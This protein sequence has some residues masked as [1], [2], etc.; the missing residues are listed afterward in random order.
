MVRKIVLS[1]AAVLSVVGMALA[2]NK[3][4]SGTVTDSHGAPVPGATVVVDG[5]TIGTSTD[6]EGKYTLDAPVDGVLSVSFIG[7][8][9]Q[10]VAINGKTLVNIVL[11][12]SATALDDVI[13]TAYGEAKREAFTGSAVQVKT[14]EI[15]KSQQTNAIDAL[16]GKVPGLQIVN[17]T[18]QPGGASPT[19][20]I[21]G[22][23]SIEAG[24]SP[25]IIV[26]GM[27][28]AGS[29][30]DINPADIESMSVLKD[31]AAAALYGSR[32]ANGV[33]LITTKRA[34]GRDAIVSVD[35]KVG[36]N[37]RA[38]QDYD[39]ITDPGEYYETHYKGLYNYYT[40][41]AG[42]S[43]YEA[44]ARANKTMLDPS[45]GNGS[46]GYNVYT[47]PEGQDLIGRNGKL[48][49]EATLGRLVTFDGEDYWVTPDNW[50]DEV[51]MNGVRQEYN[52]NVAAGSERASFY[53][54]FGY[55]NNQGIVD[56]T[57]YERYT[58]RL[59]ADYQ[60][61]KWLKVG[62]NASYT[63]SKSMTSAGDGSSGSTENIFAYTSQ[64]APIYPFYTRDGKGNIRRDSYGNIVYDHGTA[65]Q[66][67]TNGGLNRAYLS[68]AN[69]YSALMLDKNNSTSNLASFNGFADVILPLG[70]KFTFNGGVSVSQSEA[71]STANPLYGQYAV[72]GGSIGRQQSVYWSYTLQ[73]LLTWN[74][75]FN[76]VH[77]VDVLLGHENNYD[78]GRSLVGYKN[79][80]YSVD[81]SELTQ[82]LKLTSTS[83]SFSEYNNEGY[84]FRGQY[85][86][87]NRLFFSASYRRDAS[88]RFHPDHR[89][90]NFWSVSA[91]WL[92]SREN[93]FNASWVDE[94][95]IKASY[96]SQGNDKIG[97]FLYMDRYSIANDGTDKWSVAFAAKG[98]EEI[99]WETNANMNA[100]IEFSLWQGRLAGSVEYFNRITTDMLS[101]Y[102]VPVS[103]GYSGFYKNVGDMSNQGVEVALNANIIRKKNFNWNLNLNL[104]TVKNK[105][106]DLDADNVVDQ[107]YDLEGNAYTG[108]YSGTNMYAIGHAIYTK[109]YRAYAGVNPENGKAQY[110]QRRE[111]VDKT[112][113]QPSFELV[114]TEDYS[115]ADYFIFDTSLPDLYGGFG[116]SFD[117]YGFDLSLNFVYQIGGK[118]YDGDYAGSMASRS[119]SHVNVG[120]AIHKDIYNAWTPENPNSEY[121]RFVYG[122]EYTAS[123]SDRFLE[124]ASYLSLQ[125][126][127]FGYT[128][129]RKWMSKIG[130]SKL[131]IYVAAENIWY[132][133][134]RKGLDPRQSF[135]GGA[136]AAY[137]SP[138][139]T[140]SGGVNL[141]F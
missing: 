51:Y 33:I 119:T 62:G 71:I 27:S 18:G 98:N 141:T 82:G 117:L 122:D 123:S 127:N 129:P 80:L 110:W 74:Y 16:N 15:I 72:S 13:V 97:D 96:G 137:Y 73:Q 124:S 116:T 9:D 106:L 104:T 135:T 77:H 134:A 36:V 75:T 78:M 93:W 85:D 86:F 2:Q 58:A 92:I 52:V 101:W 120:S 49:P 28:F 100:G 17:V 66:A 24:T 140:I 64:I 139:R 115:Q 44:H 132:T 65:T 128:F 76:D 103:M 112:T 29:M 57:G 47:L 105:I 91:A 46:L 14:E 48:N 20:I 138:I 131:R 11:A 87:D 40:Q 89:W 126:V 53:G 21:R 108:Y 8:A 130:V 23:S 90:G 70:F 10:Q 55:L 38:Q 102:S 50:I 37:Q 1:L 32:G 88:S 63:Y 111:F 61:K 34:K 114:K 121:P 35:L 43:S 125:N 42:L 3:Q 26:D 94:L 5:T 39:Y 67:G 60:A 95:K 6:A 7:Y 118:V 136:S 99:T 109:R 79:G 113:G 68:N 22:I 107:L 83:S 69:P 41:V 30:N 59:R 25:L 12:E 19:V 81:S 31:A 54:S 56:N 133:S 4:I 45:A 84:L